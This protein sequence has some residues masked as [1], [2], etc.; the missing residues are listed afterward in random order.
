MIEA[1]SSASA[2][3]GSS[4]CRILYSTQSGRAKACARRTARLLREETA[5]H[6]SNGAGKAF[7]EDCTGNLVEWI[8]DIKKS[9]SFLVLFVSTTGDGE[10]TDT[11]Q[12]T[13]KQL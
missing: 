1:T 7:D 10:H 2:D 6:V 8:Q 9:Q 4:A 12:Q 5:L 3:I 11:I 13:W